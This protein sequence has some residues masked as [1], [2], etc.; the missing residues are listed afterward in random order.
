LPRIAWFAC[1]VLLGW[2]LLAACGFDQSSDLDPAGAA[3]DSAPSADVTVSLRTEDMVFDP[4]LI[5]VPA[6]ATVA[7]ELQNP[8]R[9]PHDFTIDEFNGERVTVEVQP[10]SATTFIL[11]MPDSPGDVRFYCSVPGHEALGM[12]GILRIE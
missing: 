8:D 3:V 12:V 2:V 7:F 4:D 6:G 1:F 10:R 5:V 9:I 11:A